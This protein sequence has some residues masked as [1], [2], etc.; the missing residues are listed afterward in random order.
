MTFSKL[1]MDG[2]IFGLWE[3]NDQL[4]APATDNRGSFYYRKLSA[5]RNEVTPRHAKA[6]TQQ[7]LLPLHEQLLAEKK[8]T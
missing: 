5:R 3:T 1:Q 2:N 6:A 8:R 4:P 7:G